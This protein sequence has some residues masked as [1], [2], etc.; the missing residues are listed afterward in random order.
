MNI[1]G[2]NPQ[3]NNKKALTTTTFRLGRRATNDRPSE[4]SEV[5][6]RHQKGRERLDLDYHVFSSNSFTQGFQTASRGRYSAYFVDGRFSLYPQGEPHL[7]GVE[8][9]KF[10][11]GRG[12][13]SERILFISS[14][15]SMLEKALELGL[16]HAFSKNNHPQSDSRIHPYSDVGPYL[17]NALGLPSNNERLLPPK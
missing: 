7:V 13:P 5:I 3:R 12:I 9:V 6:G 10:L 14:Q 8:F 1:T 15:P 2:Q 17:R 4:P 11:E 16:G